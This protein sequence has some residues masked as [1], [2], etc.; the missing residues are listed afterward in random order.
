M[1]LC[2][3]TNPFTRQVMFCFY[4]SAAVYVSIVSVYGLGHVPGPSVCHILFKAHCSL[5]VLNGAILTLI[6]CLVSATLQYNDIAVHT[7]ICTFFK[8]AA[9]SLIKVIWVYNLHYTIVRI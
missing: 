8:N 5:L 3:L 4:T 2:P 6:S 9:L 1:S 7:G